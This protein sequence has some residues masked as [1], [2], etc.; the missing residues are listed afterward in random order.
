MS[1]VLTENRAGPSMPN[2]ATLVAKLRTRC[3]HTSFVELFT[4]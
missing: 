3:L 1:D 4:T 2:S